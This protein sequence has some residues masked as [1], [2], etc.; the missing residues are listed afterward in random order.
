MKES[1]Y[2]EKLR[3]VWM[4]L[5]KFFC[6]KYIVFGLQWSFSVIIVNSDV[7]LQ[8]GKNNHKENDQPIRGG[9]IKVWIK[10]DSSQAKMVNNKPKSIK[11]SSSRA[12]AES[13]LAWSNHYNAY[14]PP[15]ISMSHHGIIQIEY[16]QFTRLLQNVNLINYF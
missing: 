5:K 7:I 15:A 14:A 2:E 6:L 1:R 4:K 13:S 9:T 12:Y 16:K 11:L 10:A 3:K 8:S